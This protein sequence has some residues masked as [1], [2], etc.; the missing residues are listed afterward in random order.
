MK[1]TI[2]GVLSRYIF[3]RDVDERVRRVN[4]VGFIPP[5]PPAWPTGNVVV[6][7]VVAGSIS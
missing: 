1:F 7:I 3:D 4:V 6:V 2:H 5:P